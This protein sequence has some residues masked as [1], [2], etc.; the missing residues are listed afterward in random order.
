PETVRQVWQ[1]QGI[2][3]LLEREYDQILVYGSRHLFD[4]VSAY[5]L[6]PKVA[7][8]VRYCGY[9]ARTGLHGVPDVQ[10]APSGLPVVLVT[11]GGGGDGYALVDAYLEAL[12]RIPQNTVH[13]IVVPGPL[14]PPDQ[15]QTLARIAAQRPDIQIIPYTT[16]LVGLLHMADLVVAMGGYNTTA[17][18]LA[19]RKPA[20]LVPRST[21]RMEQ[22]LRATTLSQLGL[23]WMIQPEEDL[24][25]R[26]VELV[27]GA[28]A[29]D[30]PPG[31][32]WDTVDLGGVHRV[33]EVL[34]E[35]LHPGAST[36][37][38]L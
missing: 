5:K 31:K 13:S 12:R 11:V 23:V 34:E 6:S 38:S 16:E 1:A 14:M 2:Y 8:K 17:E 29:G 4:V 30:R 27:P 32:Q 24:V 10:V 9:V 35:M 7:A 18:I 36:E 26:L 3:E 22:W 28:V 19:A 25:D 15:Y 37:V 21:P 20:I 33:A